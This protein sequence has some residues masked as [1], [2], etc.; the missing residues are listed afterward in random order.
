MYNRCVI[1]G[2]RALLKVGRLFEREG[3]GRGAF[4][5]RY[6]TLVRPGTLISY[7]IAERSVSGRLRQTN[8]HRRKRVDYLQDA[9]ILVGSLAVDGIVGKGGTSEREQVDGFGRPVSRLYPDGLISDDAKEDC[10][11]AI[12]W[13]KQNKDG[14]RLGRKAKYLILRARSKVERDEWVYSLG[15]E[16]ERIVRSS[17]EREERLRSGFARYK[18]RR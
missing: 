11:L 12:L 16:I 1:D 6:V 14:K 5:E 17:R 4:T 13:P 18:E 7:Q 10:S 3:V 2:C 9:H 15:V 8:F